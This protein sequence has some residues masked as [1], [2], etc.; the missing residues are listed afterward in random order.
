M[1]FTISLAVLLK[2][3]GTNNIEKSVKIKKLFTVL[4]KKKKEKE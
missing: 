2:Y 1:R 3:Y 4:Q